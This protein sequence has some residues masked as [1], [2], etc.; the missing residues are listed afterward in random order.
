MPYSCGGAIQIGSASGRDSGSRIAYS[1]HIRPELAPLFKAAKFALAAFKVG[2]LRAFL[3]TRS[4]PESNSD[5]F[6]QAGS[7]SVFRG[8]SESLR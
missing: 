6:V 3:V 1:L 2:V 7:S 8:E 5:S 4:S